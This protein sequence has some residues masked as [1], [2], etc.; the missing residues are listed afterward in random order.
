MENEDTHKPAPFSLRLDPQLRHDAEE[1]ARSENRSLANYVKTLIKRD[2][3]SK[4][5]K[6][7]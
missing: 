2:I 4:R 5:K 6:S 7:D 3:E 1:L